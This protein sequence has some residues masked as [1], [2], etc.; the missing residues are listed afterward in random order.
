MNT[1]LNYVH[2]TKKESK[3]QE[4][5]ATTTLVGRCSGRQIDRTNCV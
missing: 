1:K 2:K 5:D 3:G 4:M